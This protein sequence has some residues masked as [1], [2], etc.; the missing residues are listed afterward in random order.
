MDEVQDRELAD[1]LAVDV[2]TLWRV[3]GRGWREVQDVDDPLGDRWFVTGEPSQVAVGAREPRFVLARPSWRWFGP[4]SIV[5]TPSD[6][7]YLSADDLW[8]RGEEVAAAAGAIA[9][10]RRRSF[11]WCPT[12]RELQ[13]PE[14]FERSESH[15]MGCQE[16]V[17][18]LVH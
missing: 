13:P 10:R 4:G 1:L 12:C 15:C 5:L 8:L 3:L 11:R 18:G 6:L 14:W 2:D 16:V 9:T 7:Q 17:D